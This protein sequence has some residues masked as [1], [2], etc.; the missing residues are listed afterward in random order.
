MNSPLLLSPCS[1]YNGPLVLPQEKAVLSKELQDKAAVLA[2]VKDKTKAY[3][4][5]L[6]A[7]KAAAVAALEEQVRVS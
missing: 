6:Q 2:G 5:K 1:R 7:E 4:D 3:V